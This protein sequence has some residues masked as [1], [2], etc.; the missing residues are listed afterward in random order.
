MNVTVGANAAL[1]N[2][3]IIV[4]GTGGSLVHTTTVILTVTN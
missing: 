4:R 1:G 3:T 2:H